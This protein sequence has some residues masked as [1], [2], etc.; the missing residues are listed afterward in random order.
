MTRILIHNLE[1]L[2]AACVRLLNAIGE[3]RVVAFHGDMGAGKTTLIAAMC[4]RLGVAETAASPSFAII[5]EYRSQTSGEPVYHFDFYRLDTP[6][7]AL[8]IG[9]EDYFYSGRLCLIEWP[10]RVE[11]LLPAGCVDVGIE[12]DP[13]TGCRTLTVD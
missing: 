6:A 5:N 3:R 9:V 1:E 10:E 12:V 13:A 4:R 2:D 11:P 7:E 8:E